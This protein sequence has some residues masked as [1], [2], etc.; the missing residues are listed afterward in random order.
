MDKWIIIKIKKKV[1]KIIFELFLLD[2]VKLEK[3]ELKKIQVVDITFIV[4]IE[5]F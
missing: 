4:K 2:R 5:N 3:K 1:S